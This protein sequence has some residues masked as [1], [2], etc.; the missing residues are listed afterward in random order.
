MKPAV[1]LKFRKE[2]A[3]PGDGFSLGEAVLADDYP[4][5]RQKSR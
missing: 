1:K 4:G 2:G 5:A 3:V